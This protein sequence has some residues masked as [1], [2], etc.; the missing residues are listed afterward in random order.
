MR[1]ARVI[2]GQQMR[3]MGKPYAQPSHPGL[4]E[5]PA[6]DGSQESSGP[7]PQMLIVDWTHPAPRYCL[8][9]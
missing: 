6:P 9:G 2:G 1:D 7:H 3:R 4:A 8:K 5:I